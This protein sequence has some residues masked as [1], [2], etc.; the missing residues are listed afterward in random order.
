MWPQIV[1]LL[2]SIPVLTSLYFSSPEGGFDSTAWRLS[3][4]ILV[5]LAF[6]SARS[7]SLAYKF[8]WPFIPWFLAIAT[9]TILQFSNSEAWL[10]LVRA[11]IMLLAGCSAAILI[12][13][14]QGFALVEG[15]LRA[16]F[17]GSILICA[18][19][20]FAIGDL[21]NWNWGQ[22]RLVKAQLNEDSFQANSAL[23]L[24]ACGLLYFWPSKNRSRIPLALL[25]LF[26]LAA[27]FA[28][29]TRTPIIAFVGAT[30]VIGMGIVAQRLVFG[31]H[32]KASRK[33]WI[34]GAV[35]TVSIFAVLLLAQ[36]NSNSLSD[37]NVARLFTGRVP[38]WQAGLIESR[39]A[40]LVGDYSTSVS[41]ALSRNAGQLSFLY[42]W[43][44]RVLSNLS[45]GG[46]HSIWI[47]G[48]VRYGTIGLVGTALSAVGLIVATFRFGVRFAYLQILI[49]LVLMRSFVEA[50]GV[51]G[52][53]NSAEDLIVTVL[54]AWVLTHSRTS[55][56]QP[57]QK[58]N[59][60]ASAGDIARKELA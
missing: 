29:A 43:E 19:L 34:L 50:S 42:S 60:K 54:F 7:L 44:L 16:V 9:A 59:Q 55:H 10:E 33:S 41:E 15:F 21:G 2:L 27:S 49:V 4:V 20:V 14:R 30:A 22:A 48:L 17:V 18:Y 57:S 12:A 56:Q 8:L 1:G 36:L 32:Y 26:V 28:L 47:E 5:I 23:F 53:A 40:W 51:F 37:P 52:G 35:I 11:L 39:D 13:T 38:M 31:R 6:F 3:Q 46:F 24:L 58:R 45:G 25:S